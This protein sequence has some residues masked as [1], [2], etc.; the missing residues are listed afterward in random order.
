MNRLQSLALSAAA[1]ATGGAALA[2][3]EEVWGLASEVAGE[4]V[5][6]AARGDVR[7]TGLNTDILTL[8]MRKAFRPFRGFRKFS[9]FV[10]RKLPT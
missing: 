10:H 4:P 6:G 1:T 9:S 2:Q 3:E 5:P 7:V 8:R